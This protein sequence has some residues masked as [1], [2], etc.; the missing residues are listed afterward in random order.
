MTIEVKVK[1]NAREDSVEIDELGHYRVYVKAS[2]ENNR[3]NLAVC[4]VIAKYFK[5]APSIVEIWQGKVAHRKIIY[6]PD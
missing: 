2:A 1:T 3:A 4:R 6:I 5:V